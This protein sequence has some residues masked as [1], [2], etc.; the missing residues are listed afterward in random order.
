ME[1]GIIFAESGKHLYF[2]QITATDFG[3]LNAKE[4][5]LLY[6]ADAANDNNLDLDLTHST[7]KCKAD[8]TGYLPEPTAADYGSVIYVSLT[9]TNAL[10]INYYGTN[11]GYSNCYTSNNG[12]IMNLAA[13]NVEFEE[14]FASYSAVSALGK[15]GA[16]KLGTLKTFI[17][18]KVQ[19]DKISSGDDG[20]VIHAET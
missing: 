4:G 6:L 17:L 11:N 10:T 19:F 2:T 15:G 8:D 1:G 20:G 7:L 12:A 13:K 14:R 18:Y 3:T 9:H 5:G 16:L